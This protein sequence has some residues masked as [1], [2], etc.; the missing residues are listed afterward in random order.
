LQACYVAG[1]EIQTFD[2][3]PNTVGLVKGNCVALVRPAEDG[4]KL[5]GQ[6][7]WRMGEVMGVL[8]E[9]AGQPVFQAKSE[10]VEAT[11]ERLKELESFR[12]EL[13]ELMQA[14]A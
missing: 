1:F 11:A 4:L 8:V 5:I 3:Y 9:R 6:P 14:R 13:E 2:R 7:G 12:R 10:T